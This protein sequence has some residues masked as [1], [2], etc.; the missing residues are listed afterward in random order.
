[1]VVEEPEVKFAERD[2]KCLAYEVFGQGPCDV[3]GFLACCPIDLM[4]EL[5]QLRSFMG[6]LGEFAR[7]I[8]YDPPGQGASDPW[9]DQDVAT[10]EAA[11]DDALAVLD[12]AGSPRATFLDMFGGV[13]GLL[14]AATY[15]QRVRSLIVAH[16]RTSFPEIAS[17]SAEER[18]QYARARAGVESLELDNPRVAHDPVLRKWW[19]RARR[20]A[21]SP[22]LARTQLEM[23]AHIDVSPVLPAVRT[24]TLVF[25]RRD[26]LLVDIEKSRVAAG[27]IAEARFVELPGSETDLFL[28]DAV[29][30]LAEIERFLAEPDTNIK[31]DRVLATVMFTDMVSSTEQLAARGDNAWVAVL[32]EHDRTTNRIV[33]EFRGRLVTTTGDGVLA[34]FDGA[35]RAVRCACELLKAADHQHIT[36][37]AGLHTGEIELRPSDIAG[38]AVHTASRIA[39]LAAPGE[40]LVSR[41]VVDLAA[42][43]GLQFEP[44]GE[45]QLKGVPGTWQTYAVRIASRHAP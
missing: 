41:T 22:A 28:G 3:L 30:V 14:F 25:G 5:V 9:S 4:W 42:G 21:T 29:P 32:E 23:A 18:E 15:P 39:D 8:V 26:N 20:L 12:A 24:P 36:M 38:I 19:G 35:A 33:G 34:T 45:H 6:R 44:R 7:V 40:V 31:D 1:V 17:M 10:L 11:C 2:G 27:R 13:T 43:S 16:L 37:R